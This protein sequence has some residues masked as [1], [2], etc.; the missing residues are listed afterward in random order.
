MTDRTNVGMT[1]AGQGTCI[2]VTSSKTIQPIR[3]CTLAG[4][5]D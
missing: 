3:V 5:N 4:E 1:L 2:L